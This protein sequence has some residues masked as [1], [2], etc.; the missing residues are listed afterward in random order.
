[1]LP[2]NTF[3]QTETNK[4]A[5]AKA[6]VTS[7]TTSTTATSTVMPTG[8][9][10]PAAERSSIPRSKALVSQTSVEAT[11]RSHRKPAEM[12]GRRHLVTSV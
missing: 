10:A 12:N 11:D 8:A 9:A 6:E 2:T 5:A 1:M 7:P 4:M 3:L